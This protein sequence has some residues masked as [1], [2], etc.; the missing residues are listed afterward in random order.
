MVSIYINCTSGVLAR[1]SPSVKFQ[2]G[3]EVPQAIYE[4]CFIPRTSGNSML[5]NYF[6]KRNIYKNCK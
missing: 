1:D 2:K 4:G 5:Q 6:I 3:L